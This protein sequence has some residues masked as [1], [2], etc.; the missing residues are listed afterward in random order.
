MVSQ[1]SSHADSESHWDVLKN[2]L[3]RSLVASSGDGKLLFNVGMS[4]FSRKDTFLALC[5]Q[6]LEKDL[7][8]KDSISKRD[9]T[10]VAFDVATE[11]DS[12]EQE[13]EEE[14]QMWDIDKGAACATCACRMPHGTCAPMVQR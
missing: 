5:N 14:R 8:R 13:Q 2:R 11:A 4:E 3:R 7:S 9:S 6:Q 1:G 12:E 10:G